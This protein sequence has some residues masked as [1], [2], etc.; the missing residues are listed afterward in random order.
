ML[1]ELVDRLVQLG[2]ETKQVHTL[3]CPW[4]ANNTLIVKPDGT[5]DECENAQPSRRHLV[6]NLA[7]LKIA[8]ERYKSDAVIWVSFGEV[9]SILDDSG[10]RQNRITLKLAENPMFAALQNFGKRNDPKDLYRFLK[11]DCKDSAIEPADLDLLISNLKFRT[12]DE[13]S[14]TVGKN[15]DAMG[16]SIRAEVTGADAVPDLVAFNFVPWPAIEEDFQS[17]VTVP[18]QLYID[19]SERSI[20]LKPLAGAI[21]AAKTEAVAHLAD[22]ILPW[23]VPVLCGTP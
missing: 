16:K 5:L 7:S 9:V 22:S 4:D 13:M 10:H 21:D 11:F 2:Q 12:E 8:V 17:E 6:S 15:A 14:R 18:C 19:P 20:T 23:G 3:P 1:K